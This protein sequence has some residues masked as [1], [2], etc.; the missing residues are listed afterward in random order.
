MAD[1]EFYDV[2]PN[3]G[4]PAIDATNRTQ[5]YARIRVNQENAMVVDH[6]TKMIEVYGN[7]VLVGRFTN[8]I[9]AQEALR[10]ASGA[11]DR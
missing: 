11:D 8:G 1:S 6:D 7:G 4:N 3:R 10:R 2:G 5:A 9:E